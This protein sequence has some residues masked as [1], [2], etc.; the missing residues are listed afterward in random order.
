MHTLKRNL[1]HSIYQLLAL[2]PAIVL[3]GARQVGKST[4]VK[5]IL[6]KAHYFDLEKDSDFERINNDPELLFKEESG[7]FIF[8][9]AQ[10]SEKLFRAIR[11]EI[12]RQRQTN[13][14]FLITPCVR[15]VVASIF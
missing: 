1:Q 7:C 9:E 2:F 10:K 8:D 14:R 15:V 13:G 6:P 11:V 4:L 3:L 12:D 5:E